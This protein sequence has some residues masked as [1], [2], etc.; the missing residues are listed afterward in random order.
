M[1]VLASAFFL[2]GC[3]TK[4]TSAEKL[5][6]VLEK[7]VEVEKEFE[8]QQEPL[9]T[10][11]KQEKEIYDQ[12]MVLGMKQHE[13]I[14]RLS[15]EVLSII[16]KRRNHLEKEIKSIEASETEFKKAEELKNNIKDP[17]QKKKADELFELMKNRYQVHKQLSKEYTSALDSDKELYL[18]LKNQNISYEKLEEQVTMLNDTY[19]KVFDANEKFNQFT[20]Q[21]NQK[22]LEFYKVAGLNIEK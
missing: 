11:E 13:E 9:I 10:L 12:I 6:K 19:Q 21:Y 7:V 8:D 16:D 15:D 14:V 18:M 17:A 5:Y 20:T 2:T 22:K 4:E 1:C 3:V